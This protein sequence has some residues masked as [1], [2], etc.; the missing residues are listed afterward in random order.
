MAD[1]PT[2]ADKPDKKEGEAAPAAP[3]A[4]PKKGLPVKMLGAVVVV[5]AI[6]GAGVFFIAR[7][8]GPQKAVA[9]VAAVEEHHEEEFAEVPL[10][11]D[12]FQ[13]MQS[14]RAYI[15]DTSIVLKV[16]TKDEQLVTDTLSKRAAEV[17]EAVSL[18]FRRAPHAQLTEPGLETLNRQLYVLLNSFVEKDAEDKDR[19][20]KVMVPKCR[21]FPAE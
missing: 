4:A 11:E 14:G 9:E 15:W 10:V 7:M 19:I 2:M 16:R 1:S 12:K 6:E 8:T 21:G 18:L 5:M 20:V 17:K 3:A 13:N